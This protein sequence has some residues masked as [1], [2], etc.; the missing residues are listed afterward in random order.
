[1]MSTSDLDFVDEDISKLRYIGTRSFGSEMRYFRPKT[2]RNS[3]DSGPMSRLNRLL[4]YYWNHC[5]SFL[6]LLHL[7]HRLTLA[8][9][10]RQNEK[11]LLTSMQL[12]SRLDALDPT[13]PLIYLNNINSNVRK[14]S[15]ALFGYI[16]FNF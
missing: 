12:S 4:C 3:P 8:L 6:V 14:H 13:H 10:L 15:L 11:S 2:G 7:I 16:E 1:M 5:D 9:V